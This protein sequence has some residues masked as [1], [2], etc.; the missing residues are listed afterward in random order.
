M[1]HPILV[2][3]AIIIAILQLGD[4]PYERYLEANG[5]INFLLGFSVLCLGYPMHKSIKELKGQKLSLVI[6]TFIGSLVGVVSIWGLAYLFGCEEV[7]I[8]SILTKSIT[9]AI[10][11]PLAESIG[12]IQAIT[13]LAVVIAGVGGSIVGVGFLRL[14]GVHDRVAMG[15]ALGSASHAV[16]TARA[17]ELGALEGAV[18]GVAICLMGIFTSLLIGVAELLF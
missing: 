8:N 3:A 15:A 7:I 6:T 10:A 12:G 9:S 5:I 16:G 17:I 11:L 4:I 14:I 13:M 18:G 1:L 2:A